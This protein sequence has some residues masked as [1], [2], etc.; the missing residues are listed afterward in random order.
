VSDE[1]LMPSLARAMD[2]LASARTPDYLEAAIERAS[3]VRQ[4]PVW[5][6]PE[7]WLPMADITRERV[8]APAPPWRLVAV[9]LLT[10]ALVIGALVVAGSQQRRLPAPFGR[11]A[12]GVI[13]YAS[14]GDLYLGD[15]LTGESRLVLGGD[16]YDIEPAFSRDG[17]RIAFL[18]LL[19]PGND[20]VFRIMAMDADGSNVHVVTPE[21]VESPNWWDWTPAGDIIVATGPTS[22]TRGIIL[23]EGAGVASPRTLL[24]GMTVDA[25]VYRPPHSRELLFRG[26]TLN[27]AGIYVMNAD[28]S[29]LRALIPPATSENLGVTLMEPR[30]SPDGQQI[31]FHEWDAATETMRLYVMN[32]D[33]TGRRELGARP[34]IWFTGWPVWSNDGTRIAA[35]HAPR[36]AAGAGPWVVIDVRTDTVVRTGPPAPESGSRIEWAPDDSSILMSW[37][38]GSKQ[39]LLDPTGGP[40]VEL[41]WKAA[42]YP[43][44]Q[45]VAP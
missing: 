18:R 36:G 31:A 4:R 26:L 14:N 16:T 43:S 27:E 25:P 6:F 45:R 7:R 15:P 24:D 40:A 22:P 9:A 37:D 2:E 35:T 42:S 44:W 32:A 1:R 28:G 41:P 5:T 23:Y 29:G 13:S 3:T 34:G 20:R 33:G 30:Y 10:I 8:L 38:N 39:V 21:P 12:N 11:A 19:D 17:T